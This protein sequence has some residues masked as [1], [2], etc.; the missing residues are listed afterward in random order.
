MGEGR[1]L[2]VARRRE[3]QHARRP[4]STVASGRSPP[5]GSARATCPDGRRSTRQPGRQ[6]LHRPATAWPP[7]ARARSSCP[8]SGGRSRS[9]PTVR[10]CWRSR[11]ACRT[12]WTSG[13]RSA[14]VVVV[15]GDMSHT[16]VLG[17]GLSGLTAAM[18]LARDGRRV[19]VLDAT[20]HRFRGTLKRRGSAGAATAYAVPPGALPAAARA[21]GARG[22]TARRP[23]RLQ[24]GRRVALRPDRAGDAATVKD[25]APRPGDER[26]VT[27]TG[28]RSTIE[29]V[30]RGPPSP[31]LE[32]SPP[33]RRRDRARE[34]AVDGRV[35]VTAVRTDAGAV[36][37]GLVIDAMGR[38][39]K[40]PSCSR[41]QAAIP[42]TKRPRTAASSITRATS[43]ARSRRFAARSTGRS[44]PSRS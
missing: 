20:R 5:T 44:A 42:S 35:H 3:R 36:V 10:S 34:G 1:A 26:L 23:R 39:S 21:R 18:M 33:R 13:N 7:P 29:W 17:G 38:G 30:S 27:W 40:L 12:R 8:S 19:T 43:A 37:A 11:G 15:S 22:R 28:R 24:D 41:R 32:S 6:G 2:R 9:G 14:R 31:S 4:S 25:R 16:I